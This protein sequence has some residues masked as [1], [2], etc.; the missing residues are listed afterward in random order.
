MKAR[1]IRIKIEELLSEIAETETL[2]L[3]SNEEE[4]QFFQL[5]LE[6]ALLSG[7]IKSLEWVL[8]EEQLELDWEREEI[9]ESAEEIEEA[10][11]EVL[12]EIRQ[13]E[14]KG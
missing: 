13:E 10:L 4:P 8:T 1:L 12:H 11:Y 14:E 6:K 5:K 7:E 2:I 3:S 9:M